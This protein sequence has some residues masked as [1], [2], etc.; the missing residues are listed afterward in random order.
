MDCDAPPPAPAPGVLAD[1]LARRAW[2]DDIKDDDRLLMEWSADT[3]RAQACENVR[4][5]HRNELLEAEL[6]RTLEYLTS[7]LRQSGGAS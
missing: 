1:L 7:V 5:V 2:D 6:K 4:L 3:L